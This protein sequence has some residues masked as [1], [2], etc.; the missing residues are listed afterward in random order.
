MVLTIKP[1]L[2]PFSKRSFH[3]EVKEA[4]TR[5][6]LE[7][8]A[9]DDLSVTSAWLVFQEKVILEQWKACRDS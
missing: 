1:C 5:A 7:T 3:G 9:P 2:V 4:T 8:N 6:S